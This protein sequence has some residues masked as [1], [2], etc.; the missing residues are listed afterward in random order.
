VIADAN[1][2]LVKHPPLGR[3]PHLLFS[4]LIFLVA[5]PILADPRPDPAPDNPPSADTP[6]CLAQQMAIKK[7]F[8]ALLP[9]AQVLK[10]AINQSDR[11]I[12]LAESHYTGSLLVEPALLSQ[13]REINPKLDCVYLEFSQESDLLPS[14]PY[15]D[16]A[17]AAKKLGFKL[18]FVDHL[19]EAFPHDRYKNTQVRDKGIATEIATTLTRKACAG[20]IAIL[21]KAHLFSRIGS[22]DIAGV[23][24]VLSHLSENC[25][26][27]NLINIDV[28]DVRLEPKL[29]Q[30]Y[31]FI[32]N[33]S[34]IFSPSCPVPL[35]D[36]NAPLGFGRFSLPA[37]ALDPLYDPETGGRFSD[38]AAT[39]LTP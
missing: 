11:V 19:K 38:F 16:L 2:K 24:Q 17:Q 5:N 27:I 35:P 12:I 8:S 20:G 13:I 28:E 34:E 18:Q 10:Q 25:K 15:F 21:G 36:I 30:I 37:E 9:T 26:A 6:A 4:L 32:P 33:T 1:I 29:G 22:R 23:P 39:I 7:S 3:L 31:R 14:D